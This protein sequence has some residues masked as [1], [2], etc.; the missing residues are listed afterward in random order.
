M[1]SA[2]SP[3]DSGIPRTIFRSNVIRIKNE[4][5]P[6]VYER[7]QTEIKEGKTMVVELI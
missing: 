7:L 5:P 4:F 2:A 6:S 1:S 3:Q